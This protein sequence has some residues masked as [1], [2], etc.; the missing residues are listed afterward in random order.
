MDELKSPEKPFGISKREVWEA[1]EKVRANKGAPGVDGCSIEDFEKDLRGNLYK[2]WNRMSSGS[3]FPPPVRAVEIPKAHGGGVRILGVPT[4]ADRI[5]QTVVAARLEA[6]V[7]LKFHQ[8]SYGYRPGRSALDA[9]ERCRER[10]WKNDW[11][12]DLDIEKFFDSVPWDLVVKAVEANTDAVWVKLY[13]T[14]WLKAPLQLPDGTQRQRDRGTPQGSAVS[15]V[16]AN[17]FLHYAFDAWMAREFPGVPFERYVDDAVV[18]C[19][20]ERRA[21]QL[22]E[23]IG[24]RMEEVGLRLHPAKTRIVYCKDA[25]RKRSYEHT[26][27]TFLGFTFRARNARS[28]H[29]VTFPCFLPAV[30]NEALKKMGAEVR[31]WR[32]H[33][34]TGTT[35]AQLARFINPIVRG[36]LQYYGAFY[37]SV[38]R[39]FLQRINAYLV[40]W[41]RRKYK[42]LAGFKKS[43]RC[44]Q[45]ITRRYPG[46]FA[47]WR[48]CRTFWM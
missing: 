39:P 32:I 41:I 11:V 30:S 21:R 36:W 42:R 45:D 19:V 20:S 38:L 4:V 14:R 28:K 18:H 5:A 27:F 6:R 10:C 24:N 40:R 37:P 3:Y 2:I 9:V 46:M 13:V 23:A 31:R 44:F 43:K 47:H 17:L 1:W 33:R 25:N 34:R 7:E 35:F 22:V 48:L 15:P 16:L 8:D 12:V 26:S 29:G